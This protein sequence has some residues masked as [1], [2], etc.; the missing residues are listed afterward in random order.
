MKW[1]AAALS[2]ALLTTACS[3]TGGN[4][5]TASPSESSG[6]TASPSPSASPEADKE[7]INLGKYDP[8]V[9]LSYVGTIAANIKFDEGDS[10]EK[11][12]VTAAYE[13]DLGIILKKLW[14]VEANQ[15]S[16]KVMLSISSN[17]MPDLMRVTL[18]ELNQMVENDMLAD[19]T[20]VYNDYA[21]EETKKFMTSDGGKQLES[22]MFNG[23]LMAIP[24]TNSPFNSAQFIYIRNDWLSS[25]GL[26]PP[27]TMDELLAVAEAFT[28]KDPDGNGKDDTYA[29]AAMKEPYNDQYGFK[30]IF[31]GYHAYPGAWIKD[32]SGQLVYG[33]TLPEMKEALQALQDMY[34]K[35]L[36]DKEFFTKDHGKANE[37]VANDRVGM[38]FGT[39][40]ASSYPL[41]A[42]VVKNN[43]VTQDWSV[44]PLVSV[45][46]RQPNNLVGLGV[47]N[48]YVVSKNA[49]HPEAVIKILNRWIE[50]DNTPL[51]D[52]TR[53]YKFGLQNQGYWQ[54]NPIVVAPQNLNAEIGGVLSKAVEAKDPKDLSHPNGLQLYSEAIDYLNGVEDKWASWMKARP[55][56]S[57]EIMHQYGQNNQ[58]VYNEFYGAPTPAMAERK[59]ILDTKEQEML[60]DIITGGSLDKFDAFVAEWKSLGGD[61]M[62]KE[63]N[64]W[65]AS[66][67]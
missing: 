38:A 19:L 46:Q 57:L 34:A 7:P 67:K 5:N 17:D 26:E 65:Y 53:F 12:G 62:T 14:T 61:A 23:R 55:G 54:L 28:T 39:F 30:G 20:D 31:F 63:V 32:D 56:G 18:E 24:A 44:F 21:T 52:E 48:Y 64:E 16:Q 59:A 35:G 66:L 49:Q 1:M 37:L 11:N 15:Y 42:A 22:A 13:R 47:T 43:K 40:S 8:P 4:S 50:V 45:D 25:L 6:Q 41:Q 9:E 29:F 10:Y 58:Y 51:T 27:K 36:I 33:S 60:I 2:A 3:G